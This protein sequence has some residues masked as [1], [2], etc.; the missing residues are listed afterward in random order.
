MQTSILRVIALASLGLFLG[1][2]SLTYG[3]PETVENS[4]RG[5][6]QSQ[7]E[8]ELQERYADSAARDVEDAALKIASRL[9]Y[10][11][12]ELREALATG[13]ADKIAEII[14]MM[15]GY[16]CEKKKEVSASIAAG[17]MER[18]ASLGIAQQTLGDIVKGKYLEIVGKLR[19]DL[20]IFLGCNAGLFSLLLLASLARREAVAHLFL[21]GIFL[22]ISTVAASAIY[23]LGQDWFYT[24]LYN[25][26]MGFWYLAYVG[27]IFGLLMDVF[28]NRARV[29]TEIINGILNAIGSAA[30]LAPC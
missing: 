23:I 20:R 10:E 2:F 22:L 14:A 6:V 29:T 9:G 8:R 16:D 4:A 25:D 28:F 19:T 3:M 1:L 17:Y 11:E 12:D 7:I 18:I 21:P 15:C 27:A 26:Y 5:F 24:I 30:S 13:M